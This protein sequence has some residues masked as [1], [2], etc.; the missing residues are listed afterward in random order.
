M[1]KEEREALDEYD[2]KQLPVVDEEMEKRLKEQGYETLWE[3][4]YEIS[5]VFAV[6]AG[7]TRDAAE[8][9]IATANELLGLEEDEE[10]EEE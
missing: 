5:D 1:G 3:V 8:N 9:I 2:L 7:V 4:A 10:E 6:A